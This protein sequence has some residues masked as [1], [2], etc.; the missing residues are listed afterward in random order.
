LLSDTVPENFKI[1]ISTH[2]C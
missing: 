1:V 2:K